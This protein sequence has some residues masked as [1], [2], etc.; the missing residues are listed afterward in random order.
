MWPSLVVYVADKFNVKLKVEHCFAA[1]DAPSAWGNGYTALAVSVTACP[2][3]V[4]QQG[5]IIL[6]NKEHCFSESNVTHSLSCANKMCSIIKMTSE[7]RYN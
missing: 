2:T 6:N 3:V 1:N 7:A 5:H 4:D